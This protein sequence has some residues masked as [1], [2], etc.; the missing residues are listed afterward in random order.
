MT[1]DDIATLREMLLTGDVNLGP[2][3]VAVYRT[4]KHS[5]CLP[6]KIVH[7]RYG[8]FLDI[9]ALGVT[10]TMY[11]MDHIPKIPGW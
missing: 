10:D 3:Y 1:E 9:W 8:F 7:K 6:V 4:G 5:D 2:D 11:T